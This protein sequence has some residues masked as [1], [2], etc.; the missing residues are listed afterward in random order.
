[1]AG[2]ARGLQRGAAEEAG[3]R[4]ARA[5]WGRPRRGCGVSAPLRGSCDTAPGC[6]LRGSRRRCGRR[7]R[8][9]DRARRG[10]AARTACARLQR[11]QDV[12]GAR[13]ARHHH[14]AQVPRVKLVLAQ[15]VD[16]AAAAKVRP[17]RGACGERARARVR[18]GSGG[19]RGAEPAAAAAGRSQRPR[20]LP[21]ACARTRLAPSTITGRAK[22][23]LAVVGGAGRPAFPRP[24]ATPMQPASLPT[25]GLLL[26]LHV[27]QTD[28]LL[29]RHRQPQLV[30]CQHAVVAG[31]QR[32]VTQR[33]RRGTG[34]PRGADE[35]GGPRRRAAH[36]ARAPCMRE[37]WRLAR[38]SQACCTA[39]KAGIA[40]TAAAVG[41][42][43]PA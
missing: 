19:S 26:L 41:S 31:T 13:A 29:H 10:V 20:L 3:Q 28:L 11:H 12:V 7:R 27:V 36:H 4:G 9:G 43:A 16:V 34:Q 2:P 35:R 1:M 30:L 33:L 37:R 42:R 22:A 17:H 6:G 23:W 8:S 21:S 5:R 40:A 14:G 24:A 15:R 25:A 38:T 39:A 32:R 18:M